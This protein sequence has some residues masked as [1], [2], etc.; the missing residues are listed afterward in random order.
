[1][2]KQHQLILIKHYLFSEPMKQRGPIDHLF[3][4]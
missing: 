4:S 3:I 1:M 2:K